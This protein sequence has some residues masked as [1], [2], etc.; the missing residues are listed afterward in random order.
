MIMWPIYMHNYIPMTQGN[1]TS[2]FS[3]A[4]TQYPYHDWNV[5]VNM[6]T[7]HTWDWDLVL[8]FF[9]WAQESRPPWPRFHTCDH[10]CPHDHLVTDSDV[11]LASVVYT[12]RQYGFVLA[13]CYL[14]EV[15]VSSA[16]PY[17]HMTICWWCMQSPDSVYW[18][19]PHV[20]LARTHKQAF[21][22]LSI[23]TSPL[24]IQTPWQRIQ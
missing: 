15:C 2:R 3:N 14:C 18:R 17:I 19:V 22:F 23:K 6:V 7:Q 8:R 21:P 20:S 12:V 24:G 13:L 10:V 16:L 5:V 9:V 11:N 1:V 4:H